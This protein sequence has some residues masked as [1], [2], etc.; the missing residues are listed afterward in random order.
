M[1]EGYQLI[2]EIS[3]VLTMFIQFL[4]DIQ[5]DKYDCSAEGK[6]IL[7]SWKNVDGIY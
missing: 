2:K 3:G 5:N 6:N 1:K 7:Y 4:K